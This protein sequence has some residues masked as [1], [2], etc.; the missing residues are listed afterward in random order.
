MRHTDVTRWIYSNVGR[1]CRNIDGET[2]I[3]GE[4]V[5]RE[6][7]LDIYNSL[8]EFDCPLS[9]VEECLDPE[10]FVFRY[11]EHDPFPK[12]GFKN[13]IKYYQKRYADN[14]GVYV[15]KRLGET[16]Y[17]V[18]QLVGKKIETTYFTNLHQ[19][20]DYFE[21]LLANPIP[22]KPNHSTEQAKYLQS[23]FQFGYLHSLRV[24]GRGSFHP[25][26]LADYD[27]FTAALN[28]KYTDYDLPNIL[29]TIA[30]SIKAHEKEI[31]TI[32]K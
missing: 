26:E 24:Y 21:T 16:P 9:R 11:G 2:E 31:Q 22:K 4:A 29:E 27:D 3:E 18:R 25:V 15:A 8:K 32:Y 6:M 17:C 5:T 23:V 30:D 12:E 14:C 10:W 1:M 7:I 20:E 28:R 19:A 13:N